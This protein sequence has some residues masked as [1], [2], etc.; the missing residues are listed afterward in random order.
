[1]ARNGGSA[2]ERLVCKRLS[3]WWT[4]DESAS[5][6]WRTAGS[7]ARATV[8]GRRG[9]RTAGGHGDIAA[10]DA[11]AQPLT[12]LVMMELKKG[13]KGDTLHDLLDRKKRHGCT[14]EDWVVKASEQSQA[15]GIP[16]WM[17]IAHRT[18]KQP[19]VVMPAVLMGGLNKVRDPNLSSPTRFVAVEFQ[20]HAT[21]SR[22]AFSLRCLLLEEFLWTYTP[23]MVRRLHE[24]HRR[25]VS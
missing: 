16:Y 3:A 20:T 13:Y 17:V 25:K 15:A 6:F 5:C 7:G 18:A 11:G 9:M 10:T 4:G 21:K 24:E 2:F 23:D 12:D 22:L 14:W 1:M 19:V 8:R